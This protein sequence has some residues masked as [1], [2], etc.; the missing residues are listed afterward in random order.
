MTQAQK[1]E[2]QAIVRTRS[3]CRLC[4]GENLILVWS[5]GP[6]PLANA[7]LTKQQMGQR[8]VM[9]PLNVYY[10]SDCHLVQL[11]DVVSADILFSNYLYVSSTSPSFVQHFADYAAHIID[12]FK[13]TLKDLVID[14]GSNDG[15]LL[16]PL[17]QA[18]I[19]ILGI[20]PAANVAAEANASG[21][22][23]KTAFFTPAVARDVKQEYGPARVICANNVFAHTDD[24]DAFVSGVKE[25]L[26]PNGVFV[27]EV[28]YLGDLLE[29]NLFDIVYHEH[30]NYYHITPLVKYFAENGMKVF[31]VERIPVHGGSIRVYVSSQNDSADQ[32]SFDRQPTKR[33]QNILQQEKTLGLNTV[34]VYRAFAQ[35]IV[36]NK[37]K[38]RQLIDQIKTDGGRICGFGAPA[39]ATTLMYTFGLTA[40][41]ID[42]IVDDAPLKQGRVMPG[43]HVPIVSPKYLYKGLPGA[44]GLKN[45]PTHCLILAWNFAEVIMKN[46]ANF[47]EAG[48][49]WIIP[50][51][52]P[53]LLSSQTKKV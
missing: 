40:A 36:E 46:H 10:C 45:T 38:L 27:F 8:E 21:I 39:K 53:R 19:R 49:K 30:V 47:T 11:R 4:Q 20:D 23:T 29:N 48:G 5:F 35:R 17:Q 44:E 50:I 1:T 15:I 22:A 25:L 34:N 28:Q 7:Y 31:D 6:T 32:E 16:K 24:I 51:P 52:A 18:G 43:T 13:L 2:T 37:L 33:L 41:D 9:A 12:R 3:N 14:V 42:C 26:T